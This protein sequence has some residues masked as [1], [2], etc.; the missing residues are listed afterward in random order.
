MS[1][2]V[3]IAYLPWF[4]LLPLQL[5][6]LYF[7]PKTNWLWNIRILSSLIIVLFFYFCMF[8]VIFTVSSLDYRSCEIKEIAAS[9][10]ML[11]LFHFWL[12]VSILSTSVLSI[13]IDLQIEMWLALKYKNIYHFWLYIFSCIFSAILSILATYSVIEFP[14]L[15][16]RGFEMKAFLSSL[17][18]KTCLA[19]K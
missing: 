2:A 17:S 4:I 16:G 14:S 15:N 13:A 1:C 10:T 5:L 7:N 19:V 11:L 9:L 18:M 3:L 8:V 12:F 6:S